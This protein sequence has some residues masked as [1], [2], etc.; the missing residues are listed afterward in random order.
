MFYTSAIGRRSQS[1]SVSGGRNFGKDI[2]ILSAQ[3]SAP[4]CREKYPKLR[5]C[6][7]PD[8][9]SLFGKNAINYFQVL[10]ALG[11]RLLFYAII[12]NI[13]WKSIFIR[14]S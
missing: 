13:A 10:E 5:K 12:G 6:K 7:I 1:E 11:R 3:S 4:G 8:E 9:K 14:H 2:R